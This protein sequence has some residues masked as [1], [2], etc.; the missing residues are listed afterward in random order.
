MNIKDHEEQEGMEISEKE[1]DTVQ[2][3]TSIVHCGKHIQRRKHVLYSS[4]HVSFEI[5]VYVVCSKSKF[6]PV[7]AMAVQIARIW[8][9]NQNI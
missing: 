3:A 2:L 7:A 9:W 1:D 6:V 5:I 8:K 4:T